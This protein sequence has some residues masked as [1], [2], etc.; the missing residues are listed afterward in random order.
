MLC[1]T[2]PGVPVVALTATAGKEDILAI[3]ASLNLK[4]PLEIVG[5]PNRPNIMYNKIFRKGDDVDFYEELLKPMTNNLKQSTVAYPLTILYLPLKWC[6][7]AYKY[8]DKWLGNEQYYPTGAE[9]SPENIIFAQY[10]APQTDAMKN[11]ILKELA[12]PESKVRVIFATVAMGMGV[13][14]P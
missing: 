3:K 7:F 6:G 10:H 4:N 5:N 8:F 12:S 2:F 9:P 11:Q 14:I 13:D 1:A